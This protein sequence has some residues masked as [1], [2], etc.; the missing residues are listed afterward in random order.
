MRL[1]GKVDGVIDRFDRPM[2]FGEIFDR[3]YY[4]VYPT[5]SRSPNV[6][7]EEL[8]YDPTITTKY[9]SGAIKSRPRFTTTK[10]KFEVPYNLLTVADK[11]LLITLQS[12]VLVGSD[13]FKW[14]NPDDDVD[15]WVRFLKPI[16]FMMER[17]KFE[18]YAARLELIEA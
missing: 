4:H 13:K 6:V 2:F 3:P 9:E 11:A 7:N 8:A 10:K 15:Y 1:F 5:L 18:C 14:T 16:K 17:R 12:S